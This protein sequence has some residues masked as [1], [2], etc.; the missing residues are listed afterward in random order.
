MKKTFTILCLISA[1]APA[2][3]A[4]S[5]N[6]VTEIATTYNGLWVSANGAK[7]AEYTNP[8]KPDSS[9]YLLAFVANGVRYS[10]GVSDARLRQAK[11]AFTPGL[12]RA[13]PVAAIGTNLS[14]KVGLGQLY[15]HVNNGPSFPPPLRDLA[16]YLTDGPNG[17]DLGTGVANIPAGTLTFTISNVQ[18]AAIN[19]GVP[20]VL[21]T[22]FA[23]PA[24]SS[25]VYSFLDA[26][27]AVVG[28]PVTV[29]YGSAFPV[30]GQWL[31]DFYDATQSLLSLALG[32]TKTP[33]DLRLWTADFKEFGL[34]ASDYRRVAKFQV[35]LSGS[36]DV[37][38]VAYNAN[39]ATV[40][41][42]GPLPVQLTAFGGHALPNG[43]VQLEWRTA[44]EMNSDAFEVEASADGRAF[45]PV[46]RVAAAGNKA[47]ATE[48]TYQYRPRTAGPG[49]Y[50]LRQ[51]DRDGSSTY[52]SPALV[53]TSV[54]RAVQVAPVPF[55]E[56]LRLQWPLG[57]AAGTASLRALDGRQL[58]HQAFTAADLASGTCAL[59][60]LAALPAGVYLLQVVLDGQLS[61]Q[62]VCKQ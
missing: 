42:V 35:Q 55:G 27:G 6:Y 21:V 7:P 1:L 3:K 48:Y 17:L 13:L 31:A 45:A 14:T 44:S 37:A 59:G 62:K 51:L 57:A 49:Y 52:S 32:F 41:G 11:L 16:R 39:A 5:V 46:G 19:D 10:T 24:G 8:V 58:H 53:T 47:T 54:A 40:Q 20:D 60:H 61:V 18:A 23:D 29:T 25:D 9:H 50:R 22:Q 15:D 33:R 43:A 36:S 2:A 30:V 34:V 26:T 4:Q 12:Y 38:F 56:T 28:K